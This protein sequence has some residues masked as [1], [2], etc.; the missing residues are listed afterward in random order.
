MRYNA[1]IQSREK[2]QRPGTHFRINTP[3]FAIEQPEERAK[4]VH[5][6]VGTV[7]TVTGESSRDKHLTNV[8]WNG[9][10][11]LIFARD[12]TERGEQVAVSLPT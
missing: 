11:L 3:T 5:L 8:D 7:V 10:R 2:T 4:I 12:L 6:P 1:Q 9:R